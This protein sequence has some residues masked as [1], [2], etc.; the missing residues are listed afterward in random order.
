MTF[1]SVYPPDTGTL[2]GDEPELPGNGLDGTAE[3]DKR[4][5]IR[6][7]YPYPMPHPRLNNINHVHNFSTHRRT[8]KPTAQ[9]S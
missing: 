9:T 7:K 8:S 2:T 5:G 6:C 1:T 3:S 4:L